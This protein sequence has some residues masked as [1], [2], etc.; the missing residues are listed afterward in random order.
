MASAKAAA[1]ANADP[2]VPGVERIAN[3]V[4]VVGKD[5]PRKV[6]ALAANRP[7]GLDPT[8]GETVQRLPT[9]FAPLGAGSTFKIFTAAAAMEMGLGTNA[10]DRRARRIH[11]PA[12]PNRRL[13]E[14]RQLSGVDDARAGPGHVAEHRFRRAGGPGR[15]AEG[16][17]DGGPARV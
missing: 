9:T 10:T 3:A 5:E 2:T 6:L 17:R 11:Q 16:R 15:P 4:A 12:G 7:Y 1:T 8:K 14:R 13:Q